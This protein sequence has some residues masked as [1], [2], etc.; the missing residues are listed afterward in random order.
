MIRQLLCCQLICD[1]RG[2][3][4]RIHVT[5]R[6]EQHLGTREAR[7]AAMY[8]RLKGCA[9][10]VGFFVES[11][12]KGCTVGR[13]LALLWCDGT[14]PRLLVRFYRWAWGCPR[15]VRKGCLVPSQNIITPRT[16]QTYHRFPVSD[17]DLPGKAYIYTFLISL[18]S[19]VWLM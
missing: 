17:L 13:A 1:C 16:D 14:R 11:R 2:E 12:A 9:L 10:Y 15:R 8:Y 19:A 7:R 4:W 6:F 18:I 3:K 5:R